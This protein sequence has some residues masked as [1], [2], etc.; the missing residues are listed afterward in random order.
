MHYRGF[1]LLRRALAALVALLLPELLAAQSGGYRRRSANGRDFPSWETEQDP[2]VVAP[3]PR[4]RQGQHLLEL[5]IPL[6]VPA[7]GV[8]R[9]RDGSLLVALDDL[10][11][12]EE[13]QEHLARLK[14]ELELEDERIHM[15]H[16][17]A[18]SGSLVAMI[19]AGEVTEDHRTHLT[20]LRA[21][22][23][24]LGWCPGD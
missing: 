8:V 13:E 6:D 17:R 10:V 9:L 21:C 15:L 23:A 16:A 7:T 11:I 24:K 3:L 12:T 19:D 14:G 2:S 18:F 20:S 5:S 22:L 4:A 1:A